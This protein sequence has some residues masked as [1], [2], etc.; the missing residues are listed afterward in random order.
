MK[1]LDLKLPADMKEFVECEAEAAGLRDP[2]DYVRR[3]ILAAQRTKALKDI[4]RK[5]LKALDSGP[6]TPLAGEDFEE[7]RKKLHRKYG[8]RNGRAK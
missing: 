6:S 3:L 5:A 8:H 1:K 2:G 7:I 4:E